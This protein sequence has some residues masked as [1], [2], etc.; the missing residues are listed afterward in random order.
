VIPV[1]D[2]ILIVLEA[3][4]RPGASGMAGGAI[5]LSLSVEI[6]RWSLPLV[7]PDT[8][9]TEFEAQGVVREGLGRP[10]RIRSLVI[11]V[12][13]S[14]VDLRERLVHPR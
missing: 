6:V 5:L 2:E 7:A 14:A 13:F 1:E 4:G 9:L 11:R 8:A 10:G 12:A 3:G